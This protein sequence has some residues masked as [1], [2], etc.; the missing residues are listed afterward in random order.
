[1]PELPEVETVRQSLRKHILG[2]TI[3]DID[4]R[5][6]RLIRLPE[7]TE[8]FKLMLVGQTIQEIDRRGKYLLFQI[9]PFTLVSHL[10]ME[11]KYSIHQLD[12]PIE[13]HTHLIFR[14]D[15]NTELRYRDVR[16]F[17]TFDLIPQGKYDALTGLASLGPEPLEEEFTLAVF[18]D[19]CKKK[20]SRNIKAFLLDQTNIAGLG[21]IYVDEALFYAKIHP[22]RE[23]SSLKKKEIELIYIG[24]RKCLSDGV[25]AGG[26]T[27]R[28]YR[29]SDGEMGYFQLQI[30]VYGRRT[31]P[32]SHCGTPIERIVVAGRGTHICPKCQKK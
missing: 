8:E 22:E 32:C 21:N 14:L 30:E 28:S 2:R 9:P 31:Q 20:T 6:P 7:N 13:K 23:V 18:C 11:G 27:V 29:N 15:D 3:V 26:A 25:K 17:G 10:R 5:L 12:D 16:T 1:M 24:I 4:I 19:I